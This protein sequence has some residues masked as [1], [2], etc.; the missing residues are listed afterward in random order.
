MLVVALRHST[1]C[2]KLLS[3]HVDK[4][5]NVLLRLQ[6]LDFVCQVP[7]VVMH[8]MQLYVLQLTFYTNRTL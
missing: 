7:R 2:K 5:L 1:G 6:T 3:W 4:A 8:C